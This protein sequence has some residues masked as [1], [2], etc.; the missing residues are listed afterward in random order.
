MRSHPRW[1]D[2]ATAQVVWSDWRADARRDPQ[3]PP[4][5]VWELNLR[6]HYRPDLWRI[7]EKA[8]KDVDASVEEYTLWAAASDSLRGSGSEEKPRKT[9]SVCSVLLLLLLR[10]CYSALF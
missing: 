10:L 2:G 5:P 8:V 4:P 9:T 6:F 7:L 1:L 3:P